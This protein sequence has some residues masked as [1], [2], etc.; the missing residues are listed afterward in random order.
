MKSIPGI[1]Q[2][3]T[4]GNNLVFRLQGRDRSKGIVALAAHLDKINHYGKSY[5]ET[6]PV[7]R[8]EKYIEGIMDDCTGVGILMAL[9]GQFYKYEFPDLLFYFSEM[10][11]SKG[12]REH[13]ELLK[14]SGEGYES[15]MGAKRIAQISLDRSL[16]PDEVITIDTTPL[17]K[18][19]PGVALYAKHWEYNGLKPS[20]KLKAQTQS[21]IQKIISIDPSVQIANNT[22]D[23]LH[24]GRAFNESGDHTVVSIALEPAIFPYHQ[25]KERVFIEDIRRV[26]NIL[27]SYLMSK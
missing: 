22:N 25:K 1:Q 9:A 3:V 12:L 14:N 16:I 8:N 27:V 18:G 23:Y 20:E 21:V 19:K 4:P 10:E 15:G 24:Y 17:F 5:P 2:I 13:P 11:E 7:N 6:L 26:I